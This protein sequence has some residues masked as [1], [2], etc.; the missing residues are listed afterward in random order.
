MANLS[1][2]I[3][4]LATI[5]IG[6]AVVPAYALGPPPKADASAI[7]D[8]RN[9]ALGEQRPPRRCNSLLDGHGGRVRA[10][11]G[12]EGAVGK[13]CD[14]PRLASKQERSPSVGSPVLTVKPADT[15]GTA[16]GSRSARDDAVSKLTP[17]RLS[18]TV[19]TT[20]TAILLLQS[21]LSTYLLIL[22]L[23]FWRHVD[24]LPIVDAAGGEEAKERPED[25][26]AERAVDEVL[27][28]GPASDRAGER[29]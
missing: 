1:R 9:A 27:S 8:G 26:E 17:A 5:G 14:A 22:G 29:S 21:S 4:R 7:V 28:A 25:W 24:L 16:S 3:I 11:Q 6:L 10:G 12:I 15:D 13:D 18:A 19:L 2:N 23:P 20:G